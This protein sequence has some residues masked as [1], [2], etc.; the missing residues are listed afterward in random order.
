MTWP[1][2]WSTTFPA[3]LGA[4]GSIAASAVA[5]AAFV[6]DIRTRAGLR[7][8]AGATSSTIEL[9]RTGAP[10]ASDGRPTLWPG[11]ARSPADDAHDHDPRLELT[12]AGGRGVLRN[13]GGETIQV[14]RLS[15]PSGGKTL[16]VS[17]ELPARVEPGA[18]FGFTVR[19]LVA[20][21]AVAALLVE[22]TDAGG[23]TRASRFF[24]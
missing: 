20:G 11:P 12:V 22:W 16:T 7:E 24:V 4:L 10:L 23:T 13:L 21:P 15:V 17:A 19:D 8:V 6:R 9:P 2:F 14:D 1:D 3:Y 5:V 18:E